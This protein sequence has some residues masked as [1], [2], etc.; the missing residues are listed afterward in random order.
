MAFLA[1][2]SWERP[3]LDSHTKDRLKMAKRTLFTTITP[4]PSDVSRAV[5]LDFLHNH[6][7]MI[8]LNPL[9]I[10]RHPIQPPSGA[11]SDERDCTWYSLTDRIDYLPGGKVSGDISYTCAFHDLPDGLQT[12]CR[13][14]LGVDIRDRWTLNGSLPGEHA[15]AAAAASSVPL[16]PVKGAPASG[17]Y[18]REDVD[19][20]CNILMTAFVK[21]NLKKSH[22]ALVAQLVTRARLAEAHTPTVETM[23]S[24][25][26]AAAASRP[27]A[28]PEIPSIPLSALDHSTSATSC[29]AYSSPRMSA[30]D[31]EAIN[32][33]HSI[34]RK[35][36]SGPSTPP[37]PPSR[38]NS[39]FSQQTVFPPA[40]TSS[41]PPPP[42]VSSAS[43]P[44]V[45]VT[46]PPPPADHPQDSVQAAVHAHLYSSCPSALRAPTRAPTPPY[47]T[48]RQSPA[49]LQPQ[50]SLHRLSSSEVPAPLRIRGASVGSTSSLNPARQQQQQRATSYAYSLDPSLQSTASTWDTTSTVL[51]SLSLTSSAS[52]TSSSSS[53]SSPS[54]RDEYPLHTTQLLYYQPQK[55]QSQQQQYSPT[56]DGSSNHPGDL[57]PATPPSFPHHDMRP[58]AGSNSNN[59]NSSSDFPASLRP[60]N[61]GIGSTLHGGPLVMHGPA[62]KTN[63]GARL[64][65][66]FIAELE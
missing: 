7:A 46:P 15:S 38:T 4:L 40:P 41:P 57:G 37:P 36:I 33:Q 6:M 59:D 29:P 12:H 48:G 51:S 49:I 61:G 64:N 11:D 50:T 5:V 8:D 42:L 17:L 26:T 55:R 27:S 9:V 45:S 3:T 14:P 52:R 53:L 63:L 39:A 16:S 25:S 2:R 13:A 28:V 47:P 20:R 54:L 43:P 21:K 60:G 58:D 35:P 19:L 44:P 32:P 22:A 62:A 31:F 66:P 56:E 1:N 10:E 34:R 30:A 23:A 65:G 18:I 24:S